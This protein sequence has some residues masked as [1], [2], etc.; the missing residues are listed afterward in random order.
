MAFSI[1]N[2]IQFGSFSYVQLPRPMLA[3][4]IIRTIG[5]LDEKIWLWS[6]LR[7]FFSI[8]LYPGSSV[9]SKSHSYFPNKHDKVLLPFL[10][11]PSYATVL[12][13]SRK[14]SSLN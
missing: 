9:V 10:T 11:G 14:C 4:L 1:L 8:F 5:I 13:K 6:L 7:V 3:H 2:S 12:W